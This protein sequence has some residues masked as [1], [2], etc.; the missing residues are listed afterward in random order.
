MSAGT[1]TTHGNGS[2]AERREDGTGSVITKPQTIGGIATSG[3]VEAEARAA[4]AAAKHCRRDEVEAMDRIKNTCQRLGVAMSAE[5]TY[6]RGGTEIT[7][8]TVKLLEVVAGAWGNLQS[9]FRELSRQN[10]ESV[11]ECF[12]WDLETNN[13]KVV[14]FTFRHIRDTRGGGKAVTDERDI[15]ELMANMA[16]RRVRKCMESVIPRDVVEDALEECKRTLNAKC[17]LNP[18]R[19]KKMVEVFAKDHGVTLSQIEAR[20]Q[21]R[22]ES[23]TQAQFLSLGKIANS[24]A[25]GMSK[26]SDW[27]AVEESPAAEEKPPETTKDKLRKAKQ[28][29]LPTALTPRD[30]HARIASFTGTRAEFLE[31]YPTWC[32]GIPDEDMPSIEDAASAKRKELK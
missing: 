26:A 22:V 10:G 1:L 5:Y 16:Q 30:I 3:R 28:T 8:P 17:E 23:I 29:E 13:K 32:V 2:M 4:L 18:E 25:D 27:F 12:A 31:Q 24:I 11:V 21:R 14:E 19:I 15:Y 20:I 7:G 6:A 9:G